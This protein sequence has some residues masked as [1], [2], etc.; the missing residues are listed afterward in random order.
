MWVHLRSRPLVVWLMDSRSGCLGLPLLS[1]PAKFWIEKDELIIPPMH[2]T[3]IT[4][5]MCR[6]RSL[7]RRL[8]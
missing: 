8:T 1:V 3:K 6:T 5:W 4:S 7:Q 2:P